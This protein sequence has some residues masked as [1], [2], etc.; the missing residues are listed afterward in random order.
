MYTE[1]CFATISAVPNDVNKNCWWN[2]ISAFDWSI[3]IQ[4]MQIFFWQFV[5]RNFQPFRTALHNSVTIQVWPKKY[6]Q[7]FVW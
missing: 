7:N 4:H 1:G 3:Q 6:G 5:L 2:R